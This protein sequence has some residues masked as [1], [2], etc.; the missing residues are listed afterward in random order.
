MQLG[1]AECIIGIGLVDLQAQ[2][3]FGV[4]RIKGNDR[5]ATS[6]MKDR[7]MNPPADAASLAIPPALLKEI[8]AAADEEHRPA[9][10]VVREALERYMRQK[11]RDRRV[12]RTEDLSDAELRAITEDG[13]DARHDHLNAELE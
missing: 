8:E 13:M 7:P 11:R 5:K 4:A 12:F 2:V 10:D 6:N 1:E 9:S 3:S